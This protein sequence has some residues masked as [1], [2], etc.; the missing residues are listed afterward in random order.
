MDLN[1]EMAL[2]DAIS[3]E[4]ASYSLYA[5]LS[6][7]SKDKNQQRLFSKLAMEETR[8]K[9]ALEIFKKTGDLKAA[10]SEVKKENIMHTYLDSPEEGFQK[11]LL[12]SI[13]LAINLEKEAQKLYKNLIEKSD[14]EGTKELFTK[15]LEMEQEHERIL[16][17][18]KEKMINS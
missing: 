7:K 4:D 9:R 1:Y 18:E 16:T 13:E 10:I 5:N 12:P 8:H 14:T 6:K 3:K 17:R 2:D 11:E 15:L